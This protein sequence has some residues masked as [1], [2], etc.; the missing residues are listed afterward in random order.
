MSQ[1]ACKNSPGDISEAKCLRRWVQRDQAAALR[2]ETP[3][4]ASAS[5]DARAQRAQSH[6]VVGWMQLV[7]TEFGVR[8]GGVLLRG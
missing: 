7:L 2:Q 8:L 5:P 1:I 4:L 3:Q 6:W